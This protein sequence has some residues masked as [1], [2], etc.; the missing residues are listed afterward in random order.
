MLRRYTVKP[1]D[2][3]SIRDDRSIGHRLVFSKIPTSDLIDGSPRRDA[4]VLWSIDD[5]GVMMIQSSQELEQYDD[6]H[7]TRTLYPDG[8][9][10][11][12]TVDM[13][14]LYNPKIHVPDELWEQGYRVKQSGRKI[15]VPPEMIDEW[16]I[17]KMNRAGLDVES[18]SHSGYGYINTG[19]GKGSFTTPHVIFNAACTVTDSDAL[20][21]A[22]RNGV[23]RAKNYGLGMMNVV[24]KD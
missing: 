21:Q 18:Y 13:A 17:A 12:L 7:D 6:R 15:K 9:R 14:T 3:S 22:I 5:S 23:G 1:H 2:P 19:R 8:T 20:E 10:V 16:F 24:E 11:S 4:S